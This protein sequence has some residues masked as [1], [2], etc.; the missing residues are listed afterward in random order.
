MLVGFAPPDVPRLHQTSFDAQVLAFGLALVLIAS[1]VFAIVSAGGVVAG[2][3][4]RSLMGTATESRLL[5]TPASRRRLNALA[6]AELALAVVLLVGAGLLLR[7]FVRLVLVD[8]GFDARGA[9]AAQVTL[10]SARYPTAAARAD[11]HERLLGR[12]RKCVGQRSR[13]HH[14]HAEPPANGTLRV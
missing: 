7:S 11:F 8:Q 5:A 4:V 6:A 9:L 14:G 2:D 3:A 12:L 10:P 1:V 13:T